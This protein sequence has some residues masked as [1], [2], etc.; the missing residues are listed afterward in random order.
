MK[1][2]LLKKLSAALCVLFCICSLTGCNGVELIKEWVPHTYALS[3]DY[4]GT[5]YKASENVTGVNVFEDT[6]A[7]EASPN[8]SANVWIEESA[9]DADY[10]KALINDKYR[11]V[12]IAKGSDYSELAGAL[13]GKEYTETV[14]PEL[15]FVGLVF[16]DIS[17][18][19]PEPVALYTKD[20]DASQTDFIAFCS[21]YDYKS[22]YQGKNIETEFLGVG[23]VIKNAY[24]AV[25]HGEEAYSVTF[26]TISDYRSNPYKAEGEWRYMYSMLVYS[27]VVCINGKSS[28]FDLGIVTGEDAWTIAVSPE[29]DPMIFTPKTDMYRNFLKKRYFDASKDMNYDGALTPLVKGNFGETKMEW[30]IA[31]T[32]NEEEELALYNPKNMTGAVDCVTRNRNYTPTVTLRFLTENR[33]G[34]T[35]ECS[36]S[37]NFDVLSEYVTDDSE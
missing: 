28:G 37:L 1:I 19:E 9:A 21:E 31:A 11:V 34:G 10:I 8:K 5:G 17:A 32:K 22:R 2:K 7:Y 13:T 3:A 20:K 12:V 6:A 23:Y 33:N 35:T 4:I 25:N 27:D 18:D 14:D 30:R 15:A 24:I 29:N 36:L 16:A 26:G